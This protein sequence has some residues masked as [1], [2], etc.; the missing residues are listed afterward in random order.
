MQQAYIGQSGVT[1]RAINFRSHDSWWFKTCSWTH[2]KT[3]NFSA[4]C[5]RINVPAAFH[6]DP[7]ASLPN[8]TEKQKHG[9]Q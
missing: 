6:I 3:P 7:R 9:E 2:S 4:P 1:A 8:G 5:S